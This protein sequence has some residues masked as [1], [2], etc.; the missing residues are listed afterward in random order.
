ML[1][2]LLSVTLFVFPAFSQLDTGTIS[3]RITDS[4]GAIVPNAQVTVTNTGTNFESSTTSNSDGLFRMPSLQPGPYRVQIKAT[5]FKVYNRSGLSLVVGD[6]LS[7]DIPMEV[8][9]ISESVN[10]TGEAPQLQTE[11][12]ASGMVAEGTY[13][14]ELPLYQRNVK[15]TFYLMPNVDIAGFGYSGNLQG[16]HI[17]GLQDSKIGYFQDGTYAVGNNNGTI[18][19]TDPIQST[20][21]E[22]KVR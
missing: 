21:D 11:T 14:Q 3:G 9:T 8:G 10:V 16:F 13:L 6:N 22:V 5:G 1:L 2:L 7:L 18:Y 4:T 20:V 15:A 12:S 17:D 19:T